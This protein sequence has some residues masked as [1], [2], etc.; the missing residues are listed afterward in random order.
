MIGPTEIHFCLSRYPEADFTKL[1]G[2]P[3]AHFIAYAV[4]PDTAGQSLFGAT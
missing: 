4:F 1:R 3:K 2:W